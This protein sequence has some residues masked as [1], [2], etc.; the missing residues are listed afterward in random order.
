MFAAGFS[1]AVNHLLGQADWA[2]EKLRPHA[3]KVARFD[4]PP[5]AFALVVTDEG[6]TAPAPAGAEPAV[7]IRL[8]GAAALSFLGD[9]EQAWRKATVEGDT[10]FAAAISHL[11]SNLRWDV[12]EDLSKVVGDVAA[13]RMADAGRAAAAWPGHAARSAGANV[14]EYLTEEA[15]ILVTPLQAEQFLREVD[16][17]RDAVERLEKRIERLSRAG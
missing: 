12:E 13:H 4:V 3:G 14:A 6:M 5:A 8:E 9:R 17:L 1:T 10:E 7:R 11:A 15:K 16:E 2:R